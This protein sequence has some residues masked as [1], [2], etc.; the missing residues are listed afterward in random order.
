MIL[1]Y[2]DL[3]RKLNS[4]WKC[5]SLTKQS[6]S[7]FVKSFTLCLPILD[8][9]CSK[10]HIKDL[11]SCGKVLQRARYCPIKAQNLIDKNGH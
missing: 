9:S 8:S 10:Y 5:E 7:R 2:I 1:I 6:L 4:G 3:H 11:K